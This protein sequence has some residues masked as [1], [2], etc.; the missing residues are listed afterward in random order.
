MLIDWLGN[1]ES[2]DAAKEVSIEDIH[3]EMGFEDRFGSI[4]ITIASIPCNSICTELTCLNF[5]VSLRFPSFLTRN[6][7]WKD[8]VR[9]YE[10]EI[11]RR[12]DSDGSEAVFDSSQDTM[13]EPSPVLNV[14]SVVTTEEH[15]GWVE[16]VYDYIKLM[17]QNDSRIGYQIIHLSSEHDLKQVKQKRIMGDKRMDTRSSFASLSK[18]L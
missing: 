13:A 15:L 10:G 11:P 5:N 12:N 6:V 7:T 8:F 3:S 17:T 4:F 18:S 1:I 9:I 2:S 14:Y 16:K